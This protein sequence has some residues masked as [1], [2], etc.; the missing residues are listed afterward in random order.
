MSSADIRIQGSPLSS[1]HRASAS[2]ISAPKGLTLSDHLKVDS[3]PQVKDLKQIKAFLRSNQLEEH[4]LESFLEAIKSDQKETK[5]LTISE[6][7]EDTPL[8]N[9][10]KDHSIERD[11]SAIRISYLDLNGV[12]QQIEQ[13]I[14]GDTENAEILAFL[15]LS[16]KVFGQCD[17]VLKTKESNPKVASQRDLI[18]SSF[19][20]YIDQ[21]NV[22]S[23]CSA[24]FGSASELVTA[25]DCASIVSIIKHSLDVHE[26]RH[27]DKLSK[28]YLQLSNEAKSPHEK[29]YYIQK[30]K[31]LKNR[32]D[33]KIILASFNLCSA[34]SITGAGSASLSTYFPNTFQFLGSSAELAASTALLGGAGAVFGIASGTIMGGIETAKIV[35]SNSKI[36]KLESLKTAAL[37]ELK[38]KPEEY[39]LVAR[40]YRHQLQEC[41][42]QIISS[43]FGVG[44][45]GGAIIASSATLALALS[46]PTLGASLV[47]GMGV[48]AMV[49]GTG[50]KSYEDYHATEAAKEK[51]LRKTQKA[52]LKTH[53][54]ILMSL[55]LKAKQEL[56]I[57]KSDPG[58]SSFILDHLIKKYMGMSPQK[59]IKYT[60]MEFSLLSKSDPILYSQIQKALNL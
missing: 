19:T 45:A 21:H 39:D 58:Y 4:Q 1:L 12:P 5:K 27:L 2:K 35:D 23:G 13:K 11:A 44:I 41:Q 47:L 56:K 46:G 30:H 43:S 15:K 10:L 28:Q 54:G 33:H 49:V 16:L 9:L 17:A 14:R 51:K 36:K 60:E 18:K 52:P 50:I 25:V 48:A 29:K 40:F 31:E 59:F 55:A 34:L 32:A 20:A 53:E 22:L 57:R 38:N 24:I 3:N 7:I 37:E 8:K 26:G 42:L 6:L